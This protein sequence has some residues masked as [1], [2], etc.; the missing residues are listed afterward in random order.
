MKKELELLKEIEYLNIS[1]AT[2]LVDKIRELTIN[3]ICEYNNLNEDLF[4]N[5]Y[6]Q[7]ITVP[8][9][10]Y[11]WTHNMDLDYKNRYDLVDLGL[12]RLND[13]YK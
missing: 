7:L 11:K 12:Y 10:Q 1:G 3:L 8:L 9:R 4:K 13:F 5:R 6:N 2:T